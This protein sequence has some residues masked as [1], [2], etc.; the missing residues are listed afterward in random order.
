VPSIL[1]GL[2]LMGAW[3]DFTNVLASVTTVGE[4][5]MGRIFS[6][7]NSLAISSN[8]PS[9]LCM[10]GLLGLYSTNGEA[11]YEMMLGSSEQG[12][13]HMLW[14][15]SKLCGHCCTVVILPLLIA[16]GGFGAPLEE[17]ALSKVPSVVQRA[18]IRLL[19]YVYKPL[20]HALMTVSLVGMIA[21]IW[22]FVLLL[23]LVG[24]ACLGVVSAVV[25]VVLRARHHLGHDPELLETAV[26]FMGAKEKEHQ[27][28]GYFFIP[29]ILTTLL[30][31][32]MP[33][34]TRWLAGTAYMAALHETWADRHMA[35]Y[36]S[37]MHQVALGGWQKAQWVGLFCSSIF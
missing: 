31:L 16:I 23:M 11:A 20:Y 8:F 30:P 25:P 14:P 26:R 35:S 3:A 33:L 15:F 17:E 36:A 9:L 34:A 32:A 10:I 7:L 1:F 28:L 5:W 4:T 2:L 29:G 19:Y 24:F 6:I 12:F 13:G 18:Y 22:V 37:A 27:V 21:Y